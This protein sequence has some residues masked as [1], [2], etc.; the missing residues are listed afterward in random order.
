M[1]RQK[2]R[3]GAHA[4]KGRKNKYR[5]KLDGG[6]YERLRKMAKHDKP[7]YNKFIAAWDE[8]RQ[9]NGN[10]RLNQV[11]IERKNDMFLNFLKTAATLLKKYDGHLQDTERQNKH[12]RYQQ[13]M[14]AVFHIVVSEKLQTQ[15]GKAS[16]MD[17]REVTTIM[18]AVRTIGARHELPVNLIP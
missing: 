18:E 14:A 3:S 4:I 13:R 5:I 1:P 2:A 15:F 10:G 17:V 7:H 9:L 8:L 12:E 16:L 6:L 11:E